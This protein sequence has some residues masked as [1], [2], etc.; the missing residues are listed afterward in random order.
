MRQCEKSK[1][2]LQLV[3]LALLLFILKYLYYILNQ[4]L[5]CISI[6]ILNRQ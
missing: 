5:N 6:I 1:L 4:K 3:G 2:A